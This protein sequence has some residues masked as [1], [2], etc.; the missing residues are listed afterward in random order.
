MMSLF[1]YYYFYCLLNFYATLLPCK[2]ILVISYNMCMLNRRTSDMFLVLTKF[3]LLFSKGRTEN[4]AARKE[5][6]K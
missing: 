1:I 4:S 2:A 5:A 6:N 3:Y